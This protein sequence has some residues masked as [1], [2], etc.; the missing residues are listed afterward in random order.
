MIGAS[1]TLCLD[2]LH[3][4]DAEPESAEHR[5]LVNQAVMLLRRYDDSSLASRGIRILSSLLEGTTKQQPSRHRARHDKAP[6]QEGN[7]SAWPLEDRQSIDAMWAS[8][9]S[10][11]TDD[12]SHS[13]TS[14]ATSTQ[15]GPPWRMTPITSAR[16]VAGDDGALVAPIQNMEQ[17]DFM[18]VDG[19]LGT[20]NDDGMIPEMAWW[21]DLAS[22]Y[23]PSQSGFAN[24]FL[25]GAVERDSVNP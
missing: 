22:E 2:I 8:R 9:K 17:F 18:N 4:A 20:V 24:P 19:S 25:M 12:G 5:K 11:T 15:Q 21:T 13:A 7:P 6:P 14:A 23:F 10:N 3:R 16:S 1:I